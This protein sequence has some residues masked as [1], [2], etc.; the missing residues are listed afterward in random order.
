MNQ[1][2]IL[3]FAA[4]AAGWEAKRHT[5]RDVTAVH[6]RPHTAS[7]WRAFDS[8][9]SP[10]DAFELAAAA[11]IDVLHA[12]DYVSTYAGAGAFRNFAYDDVDEAHD[13]E[14]PHGER[15]RAVCRAITECAAKIGR[16]N[17]APWWRTL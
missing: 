3:E 12:G 7:A 10:L 13:A 6:V 14:R 15:M 17:G 8:L 16:D 5:V 1:V 4:K 9:K 2:E 11:R